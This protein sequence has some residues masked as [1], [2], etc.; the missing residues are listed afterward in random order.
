M[1]TDHG[2]AGLASLAICESLLLALLAM[3]VLEERDVDE[4]LEDAAEAHR[5]EVAGSPTPAAHVAAAALIDRIRDGH[6]GVSKH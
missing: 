5:G 1:E 2:I 6:N 3:E 4:L